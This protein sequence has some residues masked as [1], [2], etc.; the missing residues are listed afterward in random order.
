M[1]SVSHSVH[2]IM[3]RDR[4]STMT[5]LILLSAAMIIWA[6]IFNF[7]KTAHLPEWAKLLPSPINAPAYLT[8]LCLIPAAFA[9]TSVQRAAQSVAASVFVAPLFAIDAYAL[10]PIHQNTYLFANALFS[11]GWIVLFYCAVPAFLLLTTRVAAH[12]IKKHAVRLNH[13]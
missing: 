2:P 6:D 8:L 3:N 5:S 7:S 1:R 4:I 11:Y 10:N 12:Y 9:S 13:S